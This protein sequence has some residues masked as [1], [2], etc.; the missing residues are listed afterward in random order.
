MVYLMP[1]TVAATGENVE[2]SV[3]CLILEVNKKKYKNS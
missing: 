3:P 1:P 2:G